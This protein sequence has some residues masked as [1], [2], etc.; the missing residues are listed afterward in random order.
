MNARSLSPIA[1]GCIPRP[2]Y[3]SHLFPPL[4][5]IVPDIFP[6]LQY[7]NHIRE[8]WVCSVSSVNMILMES[9]LATDSN[10]SLNQTTTS[11]TGFNVT[12]SFSSEIFIDLID[13][14]QD[15]FGRLHRTA[16]EWQQLVVTASNFTDI[17]LSLMSPRRNGF[18]E[19]LEE[20]EWE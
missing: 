18:Q 1:F 12:I 5:W 4:C 2:G 19:A 11:L 6:H 13:S 20:T 10:K 14:N 8:F 3:L 7:T 16:V 15:P 9:H 17:S